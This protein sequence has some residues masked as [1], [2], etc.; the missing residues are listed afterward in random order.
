MEKYGRSRKV[1]DNAT[2]RTRTTCWI[3]KVTDTESRVRNTYS[4]CTATMVTRT[5]QI[6]C[7]VTV[8]ITKERTDKMWVQCTLRTGQT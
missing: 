4:L 6:A 5:R 8:E 7:L 1:T 3:I 2:W